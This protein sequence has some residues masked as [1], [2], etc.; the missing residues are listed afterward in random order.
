MHIHFDEY[1]VSSPLE[2]CDESRGSVVM[3]L[4][5]CSDVVVSVHPSRIMILI[6]MHGDLIFQVEGPRR[7]PVEFK[8]VVFPSW[9]FQ[10]EP[11]APIVNCNFS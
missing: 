11:T 9:L 10:S 6:I 3:I 2:I 5:T 1:D 7:P 4:L 8:T